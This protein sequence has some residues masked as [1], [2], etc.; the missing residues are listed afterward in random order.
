MCLE[1]RKHIVTE[2]T[3]YEIKFHEWKKCQPTSLIVKLNERNEIKENCDTI[4][5][6]SD[7]EDDEKRRI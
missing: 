4:K 1:K 2:I 3:K 6:V 7:V 5:D